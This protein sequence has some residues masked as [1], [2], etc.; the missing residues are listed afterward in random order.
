MRLVAKLIEEKIN[1]LEEGRRRLETDAFA[2][3]EQ[4]ALYDKALAKIIIRLKNGDMIEFDG[5]K[6][7]NPPATILEK[8]AKGICFQER[9]NADLAEATYKNTLVKI[10]TIQAQLNAYQ[11]L[12]KSQIE[13]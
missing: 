5:E 11:S 13:I 12:Y 8:I 2:R 9:L 1:L 4:S 6:I 7:Q 3:A 10:E